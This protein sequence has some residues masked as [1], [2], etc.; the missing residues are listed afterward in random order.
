M[1][2]N[3]H[4]LA[5][6]YALDGLTDVERRRFETHLIDCDGCAEEV[7]GMRETAARLGAAA[8]QEPPEGLRD[9]VLAQAARTRQAP[10]RVHR[11]SSVRARRL[12]W[13]LS[14]A[15]LAL[16]VVLGVAAVRE[17]RTRER[18]DALN[19]EI[20]AVVSAP[21]ARTVTGPVRSGGTGT[22]VA[23]RSLGKAVIVMSGLRSLPPAKTYELWLMG[24]RPPRPAG[25]MRPPAT[26]AAGPV[27]ATG[28]GDVTQIGLTVEPASGSPR[29]TTAPIF[30]VA[31]S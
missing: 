15:C 11:P 5:A 23:S 21:D 30:A 1:S 10:P 18:V 25:T 13:L 29:P 31:L 14:A 27:L 3:L 7:R 12:G 20:A 24:S 17:Q 26:G 2:E 16:A 19:R 8:A 6:A 28:L 4:T 22:V 9:R